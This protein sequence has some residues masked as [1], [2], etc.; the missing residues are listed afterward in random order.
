MNSREKGF[1]LLTSQLGDPCRSVLTVPQLRNLSR[2]VHDLSHN[3]MLQDISTEMLMS[4]GYNRIF[5]ERIVKLLQ[6]DAVLDH[7]CAKAEKYGCIPLTRVSEC[8]PHSVHHRLGLDAPGCLWAKGDLNILNGPMVAV[9]GSRDLRPEN[10]LF[11]RLVGRV[12]AEKG[13]TLVSGNARGA[14]KT[15]QDACLAAGGKVVSVVAD[16]LSQ[17]ENRERILFLSENE[18]DSDFSSQRALSRNRVIHSFGLLTIVIQSNYEA[19]GTWSGTMQNL[20]NG[21]SSVVCY[22]DHSEAAEYFFQLGAIPIDEQ[23]LGDIQNIIADN[24]HSR[25]EI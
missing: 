20:K 25:L 2:R 13:I 4:V 11:A 3:D 10:K 21:W 5:S 23:S 18:Y 9:V 19:G 8:Y 15:A 24:L 12:L 1:L 6:D 22:Q 14:D 7:Y 17:Q 16:K